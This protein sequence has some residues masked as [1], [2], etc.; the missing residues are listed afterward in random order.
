MPAAEDLAQE[1]RANRWDNQQ[2]AAWPP[3]RDRIA[4]N[5]NQHEKPIFHNGKVAMLGPDGF[6]SLL[7][8]QLLLALFT[9]QLRVRG[10]PNAIH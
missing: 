4:E 6:D 9:T 8:S 1:R 7:R 5:E 10:Q 2:T 3:I